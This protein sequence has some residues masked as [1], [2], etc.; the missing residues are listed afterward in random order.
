MEQT[1][2]LTVKSFFENDNVKK[3]FA[4]LLG[5]KAQGFITSVLQV[6]SSNDLLIK[7]T[8]E[9]VYNAAATAA[10]LELP[11]N[12][13]LGFAYILP[14]NQK[15][16]DGSFKTVAQFQLGY[17]GFIQL[18]QRSGQF[19]TISATAI[20]EGQLIGENPLL[21]FEFDFKAKK[22]NVVIGYAA[23][24]SLLNGFEK[25]LYMPIENVKAHSIKYSQTAK[26]GFGLWKDSF[27]DMAIKT[28]IKL[29]LSKFAPLSIEMQKAVIYD[30]A[31]IED[32]GEA[33]YVDH[34]IVD[35]DKEAE[36]AVL[37]L[38]DCT[39]VEDV[40]LLTGSYPELDS[41]LV[42]NKLKSIKNG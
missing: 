9:S 24:F 39:T 11:I 10:T 6:V 37:L 41:E 7:A 23:Y 30:Q 42:K 5:K 38:N 26:K 28:V 40:E 34:E 33:T 22:S 31:V 25:T 36:R 13:N 12:N 16:K 19:K 18:A 8:P 14:Y 3:K 15:Q 20:Y 21:G 29:L 4:D 2:Q 17:K 32:N 35:I 1:K 27:D